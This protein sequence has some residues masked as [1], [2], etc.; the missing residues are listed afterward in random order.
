M[1][2]LH[3]TSIKTCSD[4]KS[5]AQF[6]LNLKEFNCK[7]YRSA[8][9]AIRHM[10]HFKNRSGYCSEGGN[11][12]NNMIELVENK[13]CNWTRKYWVSMER[14]YPNSTQPK[15]SLYTAS[16]FIILSIALISIGVLVYLRKKSNAHSVLK[17]SII[18]IK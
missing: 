14:C 8:I 15:S 2:N 4:F 7:V 17:K 10:K 6:L 18:K 13:F 12:I 3:S 16:F 9:T 1:N 5:M 11:F